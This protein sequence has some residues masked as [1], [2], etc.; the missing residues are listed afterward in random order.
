MLGSIERTLETK[1]YIEC[2]WPCYAA[3]PGLRRAL[4][5]PGPGRAPAASPGLVGRLHGLPPS[6]TWSRRVKDRL[7]EK[8]LLTPDSIAGVALYRV[9]ARAGTRARC[10]SRNASTSGPR[11]TRSVWRLERALDVPWL[12]LQAPRRCSCHGRPQPSCWISSE[13]PER[14]KA[15]AP[16]DRRALRPLQ[17]QE[18]A[19]RWDLE[20]VKSHP[21]VIEVAEASRLRPA[22]DRPERRFRQ[23]YS[24][25]GTASGTNGEAAARRMTASVC[26]RKIPILG[27]TAARDPPVL[28]SDHLKAKAAELNETAGCTLRATCLFLGAPGQ[29]SKTCWA[30]CSTPIPNMVR[31]HQELDVLKFLG[32]G[33][34]RAQL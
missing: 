28:T 7:T 20:V 21:R 25:C 15:H 27:A 14:P 3:I 13:L 29:R 23:R 17:L 31:S 32:A 22:G 34:D 18:P 24:A 6:T 1:D 12:R 8:A 5:G 16:G 26:D 19:E 2:G 9:P 4:Q 11:S 30:P 10:L 33:F